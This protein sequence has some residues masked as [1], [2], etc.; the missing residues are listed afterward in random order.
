MNLVVQVG[1]YLRP[2]RG[3]FLLAIAQVVLISAL[4]I[5]K[6]W[7]LKLVIDYVLPRTPAPWPLLAGLSPPALLAAATVGLIAIYGALGVVSV[8][9]NFTTISIGQG[10]VND[11]R[12][13]VYQ[14]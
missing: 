1:R 7:P 10:M 13:R 6:P 14:H 4:E 12:S 8:I 11:L 5:L 2:Y 3:A 9:N